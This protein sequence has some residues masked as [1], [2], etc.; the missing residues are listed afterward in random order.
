MIYFILEEREDLFGLKINLWMDLLNLQYTFNWIVDKTQL[1]QCLQIQ[2]IKVVLKVC[3]SEDRII[4]SRI[5]ILNAVLNLFLEL[6]SLDWSG[7][8][9]SQ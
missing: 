2:T 8:P 1:A 7:W 6:Y 4:I 5:P 9:D 3:S